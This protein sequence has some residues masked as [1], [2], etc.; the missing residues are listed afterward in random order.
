MKC[1]PIISDI[2]SSASS[3]YHSAE[4]KP[5]HTLVRRL[6]ASEIKIILPA[7]EAEVTKRKQELPDKPRSLAGL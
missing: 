2:F 5:P 6:L 7:S 4:S 3:C 1:T